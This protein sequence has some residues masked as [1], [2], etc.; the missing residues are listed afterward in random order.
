MFSESGK[1][2]RKYKSE[3]FLYNHEFPASEAN[4]YMVGLRLP[5]VWWSGA[6]S[7]RGNHLPAY[8]FAKYSPILIVF[9]DIL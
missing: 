9:T 3:N 1:T 7:A 5:A 4:I 6:Q 2:R 8:N